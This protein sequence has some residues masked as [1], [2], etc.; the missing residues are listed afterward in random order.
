MPVTISPSLRAQF[1][2]LNTVWQTERSDTPTEACAHW[3][4]EQIIGLG[5]AAVPLILEDI[6]QGERWWHLA[7]VAITGHNP[8]NGASTY[9]EKSTAWAKWGH[10]KRLVPSKQPLTVASLIAK[11]QQLPSDMPVVVDE[12]SNGTSD[13]T[14]LAIEDVHVVAACKSVVEP[15][16][17]SLAHTPAEM[18]VHRQVLRIA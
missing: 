3:A 8:T 18:N 13:C 15:K 12:V 17:W 4:Y 16:G 14:L 2:L 5:V 7:L 6:D 10:E 9:D 1:Q 11:L